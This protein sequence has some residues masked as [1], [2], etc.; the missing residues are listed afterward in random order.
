MN[1]IS[2][3]KQMT[4]IKQ[5]ASKIWVKENFQLQVQSQTFPSYHFTINIFPWP[6]KMMTNWFSDKNK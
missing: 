6:L 1:K 5:A 2:D 3:Y 4:M